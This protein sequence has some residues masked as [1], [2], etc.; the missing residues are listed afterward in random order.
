MSA[1]RANWLVLHRLILLQFRISWISGFVGIEIHAGSPR[2]LMGIGPVGN[3]HRVSKFAV[4][5]SEPQW[6]RDK[7]EGDLTAEEETDM[8]Q[9]AVHFTVKLTINDDKLDEFEG[10]VK[11]MIA[12]SQQEP[13]TLGYE[14]YLSKDGKQGR[15]LETY[16][17]SDSAL[18]HLTGPVLRE[19]V[20]KLLEVSSVSD[21]EV[22]GDPGAESAEL[23]AGFGAEIFEHWRGLSR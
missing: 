18:A 21:F 12:L 5:F 11:T 14:F 7:E 17:D 4:P 23:L 20:P 3:K 15:L 2:Y 6:Y 13:G 19:L 8:S 10:V 22:Y 9:H 1:S 16:V